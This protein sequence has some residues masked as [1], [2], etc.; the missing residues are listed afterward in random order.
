MIRP[1]LLRFSAAESRRAFD[2]WG[3]NCGPGALAGMLG[4][5]LDELRPHLREF[6]AKRYTNIALMTAI[7]RDLKVPHAITRP[8]KDGSERWPQYGL[9]RIQ[10]TGPW[11][12]AAYAENSRVKDRHSHWVGVRRL[13]NGLYIFDINAMNVGGWITYEEWSKQ[14]VPWLLEQC[15][16]YASGGWYVT[17][18]VAITGA[19]WM[20]P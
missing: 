1:P 20:R 13:L 4:Y 14:L 17:H 9:A 19:N 5:T 11:T 7:L 16:P 15:E 8:H 6:E 18:N 2:D 3:S 10:W 12:S